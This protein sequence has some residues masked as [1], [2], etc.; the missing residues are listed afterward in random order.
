MASRALTARLMTA[1]SNWPGSIFA[2]PSFSSGVSDHLDVL[3]DQPLQQLH[4]VAEQGVEA[5]HLGP[6]HLLAAEGQELAGE[7]GG[8]LAGA[9]NLGD[10]L[11]VGI[12]RVEAVER[13]LAEPDDGGEQVVEVVG[14]AAGELPHRFHL[15]RLPELLLEPLQLG[16]VAR[17]ADQADHLILRVAID[18]AG[19]EVDP[20][21]AAHRRRSLRSSAASPDVSTC[22]SCSTISSATSGGKRS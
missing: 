10:E 9:A 4:H 2:S 5:D 20:G 13:H 6:Q 1:C 3:A 7:V 12:G 17:E 19:R 16:D 8:A 11:A 15:L 14:H 22:R 21:D 18:A